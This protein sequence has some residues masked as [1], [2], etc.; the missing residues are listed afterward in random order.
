MWAGKYGRMIGAK[1]RTSKRKPIGKTEKGNRASSRAVGIG[2]IIKK[3][4]IN[5]AMKRE[6]IIR[7]AVGL[8]AI[9]KKVT[10]NGA[11]KR[12]GIIRKAVGI[13][14]IIKKLTINWAM[15]REVIINERKCYN[16]IANYFREAAMQWRITTEQQN[17]IYH[18]LTI[19]C[20]RA[21]VNQSFC[22]S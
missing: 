12:E 8:G 16:P 14:A 4:T 9:I 11:M 22:T 21:T 1:T 19:L 15:K 17:R 6:V 13:G 3:V 20:Y 18:K 10:I 7:K 5:W 2:A